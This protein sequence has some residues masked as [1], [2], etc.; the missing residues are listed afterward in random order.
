MF[1]C[2]DVCIYQPKSHPPC[3]RTLTYY[4][5]FKVWPNIIKS[6]EAN[7]A[8]AAVNGPHSQLMR[9][10]PALHLLHPTICPAAGHSAHSSSSIRGCV[11]PPCFTDSLPPSVKAPHAALTF[12]TSQGR[13]IPS[14]DPYHSPHPIPTMSPP[15]KV[16]I[17]LTCNLSS[18]PCC[19]PSLKS[20]KKQNKVSIRINWYEEDFKKLFITKTCK[21]PVVLDVWVCLVHVVCPQCWNLPDVIKHNT[22][23]ET[24][25]EHIHP[26]LS[27]LLIYP[28]II[29]ISN[30]RIEYE[31][32]C[33]H[34]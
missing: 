19:C 33:A 24:E 7:T 31:Q 28:A 3:P 4:A 17:S 11:L 25:R 23:T 29:Y 2:T 34:T 10:P 20:Q 5:A 13:H 18:C 6:P 9:R 15:C 27:C 21:P 12:P 26:F 14:V 22:H 1:A 8:P 30:V 16:T 32:E